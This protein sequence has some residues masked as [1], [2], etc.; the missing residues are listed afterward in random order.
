MEFVSTT[1]LK[2]S[3]YATAIFVGLSAISGLIAGLVAYR[4]SEDAA[5]PRNLSAEQS[6]KLTDDLRKFPPIAYDIAYP[7][8]MELGSFL[9]SQLI[10]VFSELHWRFLSYEGPLPKQ[11]LGLIETKRLPPEEFA[12]WPFKKRFAGE[13]SQLIGIE[14]SREFLSKTTADP[15]F[16]LQADLIDFGL[17][18]L[19]KTLEHAYDEQGQRLP[20]SEV[21]HIA[22]GS[23]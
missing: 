12:E 23:K 14:I 20:V 6:T 18:A 15:A 16:T 17:R 8:Q 4:L 3:L 11:E 10:E 13:T 22:I 1:V 19:P 7:K 5:A 9:V 21:L 2:L